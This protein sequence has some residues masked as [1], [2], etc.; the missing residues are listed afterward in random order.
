LVAAPS[1]VPAVEE[2]A[3]ALTELSIFLMVYWRPEMP[4]GEGSVTVNAAVVASARMTE[5]VA[6]EGWLSRCQVN[7]E[8]DGR[9]GL[10]GELSETSG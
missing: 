10:L 1:M 6:A 5:S 3:M 7:R 4:L 9:E 8:R 2:I